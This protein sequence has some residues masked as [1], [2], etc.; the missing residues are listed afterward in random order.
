MAPYITAPKSRVFRRL[1]INST[2]L[3]FNSL[4]FY[5]KENL[6]EYIHSP[7][8]EGDQGLLR[9]LCS[10]GISLQ[11]LL[12]NGKPLI[13]IA[14]LECKKNLVE[15]VQLLIQNGADP[16]GL[17]QE[18]HSFIHLAA[19][20]KC[21]PNNDRLDPEQ[22]QAFIEL[23]DVFYHAG[24]EIEKE[25]HYYSHNSLREKCP[26]SEFAYVSHCTKLLKHILAIQ[27]KKSGY[28]ES[29]HS[30]KSYGNI[31]VRQFISGVILN[32][33]SPEEMLKFLISIGASPTLLLQCVVGIRLD[34]WL[35]GYKEEWVNFLIKEGADINC[36]YLNSY[37]QKETILYR[38]FI[39]DSP[40]FCHF[41]IDKGANIGE[42]QGLAKGLNYPFGHFL[43]KKK[44]FLMFG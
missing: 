44:G 38:R 29:I 6:P 42:S 17:T 21:L 9:N 24:V 31:S 12:I 35:K 40:D 36:S 28:F 3:Y 15:V 16:N 11:G 34:N 37:E 19:Q 26:L 18:G 27:A 30:I 7:I 14:L 1:K 32:S 43:I 2:Y 20:K 5:T 13:E 39:C 10:R 4:F 25:E 33:E 22:E 41:L 23:I 8:Q